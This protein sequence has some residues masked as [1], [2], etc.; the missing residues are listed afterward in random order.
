MLSRSIM[1]LSFR[2]KQAPASFL[3][4]FKH[5]KNSP[6]G[7]LLTLYDKVLWLSMYTSHM[8]KTLHYH[9]ITFEIVCQF[10]YRRN[11]ISFLSQFYL[12]ENYKEKKKA[13]T[14][15]WGVTASFFFDN[16]M[17]KSEIRIS[18]PLLEILRYS[19]LPE[20]FFKFLFPDPRACLLNCDFFWNR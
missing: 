17:Y 12:F 6:Y 20:N 1:K 13:E 10:H 7:L 18:Y 4:Y 9:S 15:F 5:E 19:F 16:Q 2:I 14:L 3:L 8:H 11:F